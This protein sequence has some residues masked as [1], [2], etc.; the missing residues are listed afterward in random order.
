MKRHFFSNIGFVGNPIVKF[1]NTEPSLENPHQWS[2]RLTFPP[3]GGADEHKGRVD[4]W[5]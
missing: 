5:F 4:F 1:L 3:E 2:V